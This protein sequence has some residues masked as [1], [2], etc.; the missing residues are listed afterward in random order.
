MTSTR[1]L[2]NRL[3][4]GHPLLQAFIGLNVNQ[5]CARQ[6]MLSDEN[7]LTIPLDVREQQRGLALQCCDEF[8]LHRVILKCYREAHNF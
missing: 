7:G 1:L 5:V 4:N 3:K 6:A 8:G 2:R